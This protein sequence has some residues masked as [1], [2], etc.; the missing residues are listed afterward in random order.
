MATK[1]FYSLILL[2][3]VFLSC[4]KQETQFFIIQGEAQGSTYRIKYIANEE[5]VT[6]A[7]TDSLLLAFDMS[8]STY[9]KDSKISKIN[10]GIRNNPTA[11]AMKVLF[12]ET[13]IKRRNKNN[14]INFMV[15][16]NNIA[17][18]KNCL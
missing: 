15:E 11:L 9:R 6:K 3:V 10:A 7:E 2:L 1:N 18:R 5:L 14:P 16:E 12:A 8:L 13:R 4:N 17:S